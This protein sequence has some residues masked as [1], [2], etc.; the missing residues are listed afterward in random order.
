MKK[1]S[2]AHEA[3]SIEAGSSKS[4]SIFFCYSCR[5]GSRWGIRLQPNRANQGA[6]ER[7]GQPNRASWGAQERTERPNRASEGARGSQIEPFE[8]RPT[9]QGRQGQSDR[10][11]RSQIEPARAGQGAG[12]VAQGR[13]KTPA[14]QAWS[15]NVVMDGH[16]PS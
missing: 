16:L 12:L 5:R 11:S 1:R 4:K 6:Q 10:A 9:Q 15:R 14:G 2:R 13:S 8:A 3:G 7:T